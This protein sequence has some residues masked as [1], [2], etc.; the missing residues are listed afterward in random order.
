MPTRLF[1]LHHVQR[2][3]PTADAGEA[4]SPEDWQGVAVTRSNLLKLATKRL[5]LN[6]KR[7]GGGPPIPLFFGEKIL[8]IL[9]K[10]SPKFHFVIG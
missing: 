4:S 6:R 9:T 7:T 10:D 1:V 3:K 5:T 2:S 8:K